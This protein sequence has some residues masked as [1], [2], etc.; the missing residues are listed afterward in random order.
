MEEKGYKV[1]QT[2]LNQDN[3]STILLEENGKE[4]SSKR[5]RHI[6]IQYF[7]I[8]DCVQRGEFTIEFCPTDDMWADFLTKPLQGKKF[9]KLRRILMNHESTK[10]VEKRADELE[11]KNVATTE[12]KVAKSLK[13]LCSITANL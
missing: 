4:S 8:T 7:F 11:N 10:I 1:S 5:T 12:T 13:L 6:N 3:K 9:M 2:I